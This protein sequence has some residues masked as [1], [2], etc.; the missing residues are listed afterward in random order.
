MTLE[1]ETGAAA[2]PA[3]T[4]I[5]FSKSDHAW[6]SITVDEWESRIIV[7]GTSQPDANALADAIVARLK[8]ERLFTLKE[9][10]DGMTEALQSARSTWTCPRCET[11]ST[12]LT[13]E[14]IAGILHVAEKYSGQPRPSGQTDFRRGWLAA[15][16]HIRTHV[17]EA[18]GR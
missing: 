16:N 13:G 9:L 5:D 6:A 2:L 3:D 10:V 12:P 11:S 14:H 1:R 17:Q 4:V 18:T 7:F 8:G 15:I